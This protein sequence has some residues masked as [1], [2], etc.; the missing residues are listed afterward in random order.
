MAPH[1]ILQ[2]QPLRFSKEKTLGQGCTAGTRTQ[3]LICP[4]HAPPHLPHRLPPHHAW[5]LEQGFHTHTS[6]D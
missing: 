6:H 4:H 1:P 3:I 5:A 2:T